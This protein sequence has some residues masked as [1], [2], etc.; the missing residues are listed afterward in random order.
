MIDE[1][2]YP[3]S[4]GV[5]Q[6]SI[7]LSNGDSNQAV[8][9]MAI[10]PKN[11]FVQL[12]V[13][14]YNNEV[15]EQHT[16]G[17]MIKELESKGQ[18]V[19]A[20]V[21]GD[22]FSTIGVPSGLQ[23]SDGEIM[24]SPSNIKT[25]M[26][27]MPDKTVKLE[28][29]V[30]MTATVTAENGDAISIDMIN[31][32][33][34]ISHNNHVFLYTK[35][36]GSS[37]RT[38]DGGIEAVVDASNPR[39]KLTAG[40]RLT[41]TVKS[42]KDVYD[43]PISKGTFVLSASG[44]KA[45]WLSAHLRAGE[46]VQVDVS[47]DKSVNR[48]RQVVSGNST[49]GFVLLKNGQ[50]PENILDPSDS[51]NTDQA[52]RTILAT[53]QGK[54]YVLSV[55]GRQSG[56]SDGISLIE[57]AHYLQSLGMEQAINIDG[58]GSTTY[59]VRQPGNEHPTLINH[60]S[61]GPERPVG[62]ALM[63][64]TTAPKVPKLNNLIVD[65]STSVKVAPGSTLSFKTKGQDKFFNPLRVHPKDLTWS[66]KGGIGTV[67]KTGVFKA[68]QKEGVGQ[69]DAWQHRV[70]QTVHV[71]VTDQIARLDIQPSS[72]VIDSGKNVDFQVKAYDAAGNPIIISPDCLQWSTEGDIGTI[73]SRGLLQ[74]ANQE[75]FGKVYARYGDLTATS[76]VH[77][78]SS[79]RIEDFENNSSLRAS[80]VRTV[81]GSVQLSFVSDPKPIHG[82]YAA[83]LTYDFT[84]TPETSGAYINFLNEN[85]DIGREIEGKPVRL[86]MWVYG[87]AKN[88]QV[89][90]GITDGT[91]KNQIW[92]LTAWEGQNWVGWKYVYAN[93]PSDTVFPIKVRNVEIEEKYA[94]NKNAGALYFDDFQAVYFDQE[95]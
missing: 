25:L 56:F 27:V 75:A 86:G 82:Q 49:L 85:G 16:V 91:G 71:T 40:H 32:T 70:H 44:S 2:S 72:F 35:H 3:V 11:P 69:I 73:S 84:D 95:N 83:K 38:P 4:P 51:N 43:S 7:N 41:G 81:P 93:V 47:F 28:D 50:I 19:V 22:F 55:D 21:N 20:G 54:L 8:Q 52:P 12:K 89:R 39:F 64:V 65:P 34:A 9:L 68:S 80:E 14:S 10:D 87:D 53:K 94:T 23:I 48:A 76:T 58:G 17:T 45:D 31:R 59:Y 29:S 15:S 60:P 90:L 30:H 33:R 79:P 5:S 24:T 78:G 42:I 1:T 66:V 36:F 74:T 46:K 88:H 37:T 92:N 13:R 6:S 77:V 57:A 61:D 26:M 18:R 62:N 63:V 67:N